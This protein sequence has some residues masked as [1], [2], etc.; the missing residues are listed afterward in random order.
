MVQTLNSMLYILRKS[1]YK[2]LS[3]LI[4]NYLE[5]QNHSKG[6]SII[7]KES[8]TLLKTLMKMALILMLQLIMMNLRKKPKT[9][10]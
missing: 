7:Q 5:V 8:K 3:Y 1:V 9:K 4:K 10:N 2:I 6:R